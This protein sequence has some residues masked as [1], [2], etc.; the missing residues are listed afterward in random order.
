MNK[1][2][3]RVPLQISTEF[4]ICTR[5]IRPSMK[6]L[7]LFSKDSRWFWV[8]ISRNKTEQLLLPRFPNRSF[9][10]QKT[11]G[12]PISRKRPDE[13]QSTRTW[14]F[15]QLARLIPIK[16]LKWRFNYWKFKLYYPFQTKPTRVGSWRWCCSPRWHHTAEAHGPQ[17]RI[18]LLRPLKIL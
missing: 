15:E 13:Q 1:F 17:I 10:F 6:R 2:K 18:P 11:Q 3:N 14:K 8:P 7:S 5:H 12:K 16:L 4:K 9:R